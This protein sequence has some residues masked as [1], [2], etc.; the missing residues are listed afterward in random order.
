MNK[1]FRIWIIN[2]FACTPDMP[3]G[4][5]HYEIAKH[6]EKNGFEV[7]IFAS[8]FNLSS[9]NFL[10]LN[11]IEFM[12]KE[13]NEG[14]KFFWLKTFPYKKNNWKR[15]LNLISFCFTEYSTLSTG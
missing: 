5:R 11:N 1:K 15:Y 8:D 10:R 2:Q 12:K 13:L 4:S 14:V 6:F 3:G 7:N 9:R